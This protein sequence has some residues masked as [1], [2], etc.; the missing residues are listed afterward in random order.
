M[1]SF[2]L[3]G[4]VLLTGALCGKLMHR[5]SMP[6]VTGYILAGLL[7]GVSGFQLVDS[8]ALSQFSFLSDFALCVIAFTIGSELELK[9]IRKLGRS[10]FYISLLEAAVTFS[11]V[12]LLTL[13][14]T[15]DMALAVVLGAVSTAAAPAATIMVLRELGARGEVTSTLVGVIAVVDAIALM[16]FSVAIAVA[17][18]LVVKDTMSIHTILVLPFQEIVY[19]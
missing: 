19:Q 2:V 8:Q 4:L 1:N 3:I 13:A 12:G 18:V 10:I 9:L 7:L 5:I 17:R 14:L 11:L 15:R 6:A 16:F